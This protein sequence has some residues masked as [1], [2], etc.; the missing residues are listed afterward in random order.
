MWF[1]KPSISKC[2][3]LRINRNCD[4]GI[5]GCVHE[6]WKFLTVN[7]I[8]IRAQNYTDMIAAQHEIHTFEVVIVV[9]LLLLFDVFA[10]T[11]AHPL[12]FL[13]N[14]F[15][16]IYLYPGSEGNIGTQQ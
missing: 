3:V 13:D 8:R 4:L 2:R 12:L 16:Q 9:L 15:V 1:T 7:L 10:L 5:F 14:W 6:F 11:S